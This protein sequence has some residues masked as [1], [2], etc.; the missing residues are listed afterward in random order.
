MT[1]FQTGKIAKEFSDCEVLSQSRATGA[2]EN[3]VVEITPAQKR[4]GPGKEC[5]QA[6]PEPIQLPSHEKNYASYQ[7]QIKDDLKAARRTG[8]Y[9]EQPKT[10]QRREGLDMKVESHAHDIIA[11]IHEMDAARHPPGKVTGKE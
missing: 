7:F 11:T 2:Q 1:W 9:V 8:V 6:F 5:S 4:K 10:S 3:T